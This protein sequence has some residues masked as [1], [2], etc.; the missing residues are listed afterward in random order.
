[1]PDPLPSKAPPREPSLEEIVNYINT[2]RALRRK[3]MGESAA[4][5]EQA[6][7]LFCRRLLTRLRLVEQTLAAKGISIEERTQS[8]LIKLPGT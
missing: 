7:A 1:M 8:G 5:Q 6:V 3:L 2:P 4:T